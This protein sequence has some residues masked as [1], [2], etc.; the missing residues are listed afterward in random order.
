M[1]RRVL[2]LLAALCLT[3]GA[4]AAFSDV[5]EES[6]FSDEVAYVV[7]EGLMQ[8]VSQDLF[9]PGW[10]VTRGTVVTVLYRLEDSPAP[11]EG[12]VF[13]DVAADTWYA[14]AVNWARNTGIAAG[15]DSGNFGP[16]D[17]VTREQLAVFLWRYAQYK[18]LEIAQG[19]TGG[20]S[21]AGK[22]STWAED[23]MKH[24]VGAGLLAGKDGGLL[25]PGGI[26]TRAELAAILQR[27]N[28]PVSG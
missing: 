1:L 11:E 6:W 19:V 7:Q 25:D 28:T 8:G 20:F 21:D 18:G 5:N 13:P 10:A 12:P 14:N 2:A 9:A 16:D 4:A 15:Y 24:A 23:G 26:A 3:A 17:P 27:L 22:I